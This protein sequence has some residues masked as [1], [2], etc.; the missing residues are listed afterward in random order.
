MYTGGL[1]SWLMDSCVI[2]NTTTDNP[3]GPNVRSKR[4]E[5][6]DEPS[7]S[8]NKS[9]VVVH[10]SQPGHFGLLL[11]CVRRGATVVHIC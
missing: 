4:S 7:L 3:Q 5:T 2:A 6:Q 10:Y 11:V 1:G 9:N 8:D